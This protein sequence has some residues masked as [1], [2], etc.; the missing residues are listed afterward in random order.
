MT[1]ELVS[2]KTGPYDIKMTIQIT[3]LREN[4]NISEC[5]LNRRGENYYYLLLRYGLSSH[6]GRVVPFLYMAFLTSC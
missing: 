4:S 3:S 6:A 2:V 5:F 1:Y